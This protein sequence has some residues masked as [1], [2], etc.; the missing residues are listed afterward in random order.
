MDPTAAVL[1]GSG[2]A[3]A[4]VRALAHG[5][6]I[7]ATY[8]A[9]DV[10]GDASAAFKRAFRLEAVEGATTFADLIL[11]GARNRTGPGIDC[12]D[13]HRF[14]AETQLRQCSQPGHG[15]Y[16]G[17]CLLRYWRERPAD[18]CRTDGKFLDAG[19]FRMTVRNSCSATLNAVA[20][21]NS[22]S[23][24]MCYCD[25]TASARA[26]AICTR[27][28]SSY[29]SN[30][31]EHNRDSN[32]RSMAWSACSTSPALSTSSRTGARRR[33]RSASSSDQSQEVAYA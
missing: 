15:F 8:G 24:G 23:T 29:V 12:E 31:C 2:P 6:L 9:E 4:L 17:H 25:S 18:F 11:R 10:L 30:N 19:N 16:D 28:R 3:D 33:N 20:G 14:I 1:S 13:P 21:I 32:A 27:C 26:C 5:S 7:V 22:Q